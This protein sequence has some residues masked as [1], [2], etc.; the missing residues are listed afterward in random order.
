MNDWS[1]EL[2]HEVKL[3]FLFQFQENNKED[4]FDFCAEGIPL[5]DTS[6]GKIMISTKRQNFIIFTAF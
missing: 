5:A 1:Y 2:N 6:E 4:L 3:S